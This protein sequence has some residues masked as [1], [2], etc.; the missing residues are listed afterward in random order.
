M[1]NMTQCDRENILQIG[2]IKI[3]GKLKNR[4]KSEHDTKMLV[5]YKNFPFQARLQ[6]LNT[7]L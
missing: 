1:W 2:K 5:Q 3:C 6:W 4:I 7:V